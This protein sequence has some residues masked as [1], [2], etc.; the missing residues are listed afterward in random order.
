[1]RTR[2]PG[3]ALCVVAVLAMPAAAETVDEVKEKVEKAYGALKSY[4]CKYKMASNSEGP[5]Y[6]VKT[7]ADGTLEWARKGD[8]SLMRTEM[9]TTFEQ[10][11]QGTSSKQ[12]AK[13]T[14]YG[15]GK[16]L[17]SVT[18]QDGQTTITKLQDPQARD[19]SPWETFKNAAYSQPTLKVLPDEKVDGAECFV[20]EIT[21]KVMS[22]DGDA[23]TGRSVV[24][25]RK[26]CGLSVKFVSYI[27][28]K[29]VSE[30]LVTDLK[31]NPDIKPERFEYAPPAGAPV[32]DLARP[33]NP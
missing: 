33:G 24:H 26:D 16:T 31:V 2:I 11:V 20:V 22:P 32:Q 9:T 14:S 17:W 6:S 27:N 4:A 10:S 28:D 1:M 18:E 13:S 12:T 7:A 8:R 3:I 5:G 21:G 29:L 30:M 19:Q 23:P 25:F 15:D